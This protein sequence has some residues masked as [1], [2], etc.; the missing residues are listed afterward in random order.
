MSE[1]TIFSNIDLKSGYYQIRIH[2]E[3][4]SKTAFKTKDGLYDWI[5][6]PFGLT[7]STIISMRVMAQVL[8]SFMGKFFIVYFNDILIYSMTLEHYINHLS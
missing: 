1:V 4:E 8:R 3:D 6:M 2:P 7:D 5:A